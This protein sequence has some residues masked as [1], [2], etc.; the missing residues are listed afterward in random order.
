M[1]YFIRNRALFIEVKLVAK[2]KLF[3]VTNYWLI[4]HKLFPTKNKEAL[5][6]F[7]GASRFELKKRSC[8]IK[9][10]LAPFVSG[11]QSSLAVFN[12]YHFLQV[13]TLLEMLK[14]FTGM[15]QYLVE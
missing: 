1:A 6:Q 10:F 2:R 5:I 4:L 13:N 9:A 14:F 12:H 8:R 11:L 7:L 3:W 15:C